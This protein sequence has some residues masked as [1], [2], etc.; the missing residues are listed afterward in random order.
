[1]FYMFNIIY[2][3]SLPQLMLKLYLNKVGKLPFGGKLYSTSRID[4]QSTKLQNQSPSHI[5]VVQEL[6]SSE[7]E[8]VKS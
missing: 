8:G 5:Y 4:F 1:M 3:T 7:M 2:L 6:L